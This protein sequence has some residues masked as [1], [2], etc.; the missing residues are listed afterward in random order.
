VALIQKNET[1][2]GQ[3]RRRKAKGK[4]NNFLLMLTDASVRFCT[5]TP[6]PSAR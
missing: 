3:P 2:R 6:P 5:E 1:E 4:M